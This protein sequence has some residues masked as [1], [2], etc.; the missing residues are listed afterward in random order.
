MLLGVVGGVVPSTTSTRLQTFQSQAGREM[1]TVRMYA[2][3]DSTWPD[4]LSSYAKAH[5]QA[6]VLSVK[7][8][9]QTGAPV[10][11]SAVAAAQP[12][13]ATYD[14]IVRWAQ[15][16]R[17]YGAPMFFTF[18]HEPEV[19]KSDTFGTAA[20]YVMAWRRIVTVFRQE[21]VRNAE[22]VFIGT[23]FG[24]S[25]T[26]QR[27]TAAYYP[28]DDFVD[29]IATDGYNW[30]TCRPNAQIEWASARSLLEGLRTFGRQHPRKG[31]MVGELG[32]VEDPAVPG[33]KAQ[34]YRDAQAL[35][36]EPGYGQF[37]AV[38]LWYAAG[39]PGA[40]NWQINTSAATQS[41]FQ[42]WGA[43]PRYTARG[44]A[45]AS[46][47]LV[48]STLGAQPGTV[49]VSW[50]PAGPGASGVSAYV[51]TVQETGE[52]FR[53]DGG[54]DGYRYAGPPTGTFTVRA[55]N[56]QGA[57]QPSAPSTVTG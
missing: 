8:K 47:R 11:Y 44:V 26:D 21:G 19:S 6:V 2:L 14:Q 32:S 20:E 41:A 48:R 35:L 9:T 30:H 29:D 27:A 54:A 12:G 1:A 17:G 13:D 52:V 5:G 57:S 31:L 39:N 23:S 43:D 4:P 55:V 38:A 45:P 33:R 22:Y 46:P 16:V 15:M 51:V 18:N 10:P 24:W 56:A 49:D 7:S 53:V 36:A 25:R 50:A 42:E 40:C 28:G 3:W 37:R 34:W